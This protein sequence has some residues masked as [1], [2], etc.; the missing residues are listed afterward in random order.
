MYNTTPTHPDG[1]PLTSGEKDEQ[2]S[3]LAADGTANETKAAGN[4]RAAA[5]GAGVTPSGEA[6]AALNSTGNGWFEDPPNIKRHDQGRGLCDYYSECGT[7]CVGTFCPCVTFGQQ[8]EYTGMGSC[9]L[10]GCLYLGEDRRI[11]RSNTS[12]CRAITSGAVGR[13]ETGRMRRTC[14]PCSPSRFSRL[15]RR[16]GHPDRHNRRSYLLPFSP[17]SRFLSTAAHISLFIG[18]AAKCRPLRK[19]TRSCS[20]V[21]SINQPP[22]MPPQR[23]PAA[24]CGPLLRC[25]WLCTLDTF[26]A[27]RSLALPS[28]LAAAFFLHECQAFA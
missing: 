15:F 7:C 26:P 14:D 1:A 8:A 4:E 13:N 27:R 23:R 12:R 22:T 10:C 18:V 24:P 19:L 9:I 3:L 25:P 21:D 6:G 20:R 17:L 16:H 11:L 2:A 5:A 28:K